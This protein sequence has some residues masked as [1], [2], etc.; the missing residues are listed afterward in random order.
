MGSGIASAFGT[1]ASS[2]SPIIL[3]LFDRKKLNPN[4]LFAI[5]SLLSIGVL[6]LLP[7]TQGKPLKE[8]I[9]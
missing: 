2:L 8:E 9:E 6:S 4:I 7:E 1:L 5:L 3:G